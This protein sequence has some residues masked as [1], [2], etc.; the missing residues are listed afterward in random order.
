[1]QLSSYFI[2]SY[3]KTFTKCHTSLEIVLALLLCM[4]LT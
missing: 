4:Q 2:Y 3:I 1:M